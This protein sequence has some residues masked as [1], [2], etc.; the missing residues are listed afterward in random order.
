M[1][2]VGVVVSMLALHADAGRCRQMHATGVQVTVTAQIQIC[3]GVPWQFGSCLKWRSRA[4]KPRRA[5]SLED[6]DED[7]GVVVKFAAS[8]LT[9]V[10]LVKIPSP[11]YRQFRFMPKMEVHTCQK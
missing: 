3:N 4:Y 10:N 6:E 7:V 1:G 2:A 5:C 9:R 8:P 11:A